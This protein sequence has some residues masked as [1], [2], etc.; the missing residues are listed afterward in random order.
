MVE[1]NEL[2]SGVIRTPRLVKMNKKKNRETR[3]GNTINERTMKM[4]RENFPSL[5]INKILNQFFKIKIE[6]MYKITIQETIN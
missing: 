4:R 3:G 5:K 1:K 2:Q 6:R